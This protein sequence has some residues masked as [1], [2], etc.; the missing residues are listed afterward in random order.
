MGVGRCYRACRGCEDRKL[1]R[2]GHGLVFILLACHHSPTTG[3]EHG[4]V[5]KLWGSSPL[6][7]ALALPLQPQVLA[8]SHGGLNILGKKSWNVWN[9]DNRERVARDE[10]QLAE[11]ENAKRRRA[12][13]AEQEARL[14]QLRARAHRPEHVAPFSAP[15]DGALF[16]GKTGHI[17]LFA[18]ADAK[19]GAT[20]AEAEA[21]KKAKKDA[22]ERKLGIVKYLD[23][24]AHKTAWYA[25]RGET[26]GDDEDDEGR[27]QSGGEKARFPL[28]AEARQ[29]IDEARK[30]KSDPA[31]H[32]AALLQ[33]TTKPPAA[34]RGGASAAKAPGKPAY[35]SI[36]ALRAERDAR[37]RAER[38]KAERLA[39]PSAGSVAPAQAN[40]GYNSAYMRR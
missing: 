34:A 31:T 36:A 19:T 35:D 20:N 14:T 27:K 11:E 13:G 16:D 9:R 32:M 22:E 21:E 3:T 7:R 18:D 38:A 8:M 6:S 29:R 1:G 25:K 4:C 23:E 24:G 39:Q 40:R 12:E 33:Q 15:A 2:R 5:R 28:S 30:S 10:A 17:N 26:Q 37:E